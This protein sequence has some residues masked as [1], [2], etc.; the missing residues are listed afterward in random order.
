MRSCT[1]SKGL[2]VPSCASRKPAQPPSRGCAA[3]SSDRVGL[4][5]AGSCHRSPSPLGSWMFSAAR[6]APPATR[7]RPASHT[8]HNV[9]VLLLFFFSRAQGESQCARSLARRFSEAAN[10]PS[11]LRQESADLARRFGRAPGATGR[12]P[13]D[14]CR[15][16]PLGRSHGPVPALRSAP[17]YR[18]AATRRR[19]W[20]RRLALA[21]RKRRL[22]DVVARRSAR[23]IRGRWCWFCSR[24]RKASTTSRR[25]APSPG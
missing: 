18:P 13:H 8:T 6:L 2:S 1:H 20:N 22:V 14:R 11:V 17:R 21:A 25:P 12:R 10:R 23:K 15:S 16:R 24:P 3:N 19:A 4:G 5:E 7:E 9:F